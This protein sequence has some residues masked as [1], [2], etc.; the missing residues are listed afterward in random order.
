MY[1]RSEKVFFG[2]EMNFRGDRSETK[3]ISCVVNILNIGYH[4]DSTLGIP[5]LRMRIFKNKT[6]VILINV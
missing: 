1:K 3:I 2:S 4:S 6:T 5:P